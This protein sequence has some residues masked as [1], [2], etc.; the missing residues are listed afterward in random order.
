M[1]LDVKNNN[2][3]SGP[4]KRVVIITDNKKHL[5]RDRQALRVVGLEFDAHY[6]ATQEAYA[7]LKANGCDLVILDHEVEGPKA[8]A[9]LKQIQKDPSLK[10]IPVIM[11]TAVN[12]RAAVLDA[13]AS[14]VSG[15]ILRPYA[16]ETFERH[17]N[18]AMQ[19]IRYN[20]IETRQISDAKLMMET[21]DFDEAIEEFEEVL[22][23]HEEAK[24]FYDMGCML[25]A[26]EKY[27][28]AIVAFQK[29][30]K[31]NDMFADAYHGMAE[32]YKNKGDL[33]QCQFY[34][35]R[36][37]D[38]FA[39]T[40]RLE[41][42]KEVFIDILKFDRRAPNPFNSLGV[43]LRKAGDVQGAIQA[44]SQALELTPHDENVHFNMA[45]AYYFL[46]DKKAALEKI[47]TALSIN[48]EFPEALKMYRL[49]KGSPWPGGKGVA[50]PRPD[51][52]A[53]K[54]V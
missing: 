10:R 30:V 27:G 49:L 17:I 14:G 20:E 40:D 28:K 38:I 6:G 51:A 53:M 9:F 43:K 48:A 19:L 29:A 5:D 26:K 42:V 21:G 3:R 25:L 37:A 45:K 7:A 24:K 8:N 23:Q 33:E 31:I 39:E 44:Y 54:D 41:K 52:H 15:Y 12:E 22:S 13:V 16:D 2:K 47:T 50:S 36:A 1:G 18:T 46:G 32:A 4:P 34:L 11:V 35:Q